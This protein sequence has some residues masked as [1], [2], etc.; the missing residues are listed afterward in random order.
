MFCSSLAIAQCAKTSRSL[1]AAAAESASEQRVATLKNAEG[2]PSKT[3]RA[4]G[5]ATLSDEALILEY[6]DT[7]NT[8]LFEE[9]VRRYHGPLYRF[10]CGYLGEKTLA[11]D[12]LQNTLLKVHLKC[13]LYL[14]GGPVW[15]WLYKIATRQAIDALRRD[16]RFASV[17]LA[18]SPEDGDAT[19]ADLLMCASP[20][21]LAAAQSAERKQIVRASVARLPE[22]FRQVVTLAYFE[23]MSYGEIADAL[24]IPLGTVK[25]RLHLAIGRL[26]ANARASR[27]YEA[28]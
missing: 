22:S 4:G 7:G 17:R 18:H 5:V 16:E 9:L 1:P 15:P 25:S 8:E 23:G 28:G 6:R 24:N 19:M 21:P 10:L 27:S 2:R 20:G 14:P 26:R 11:E 13:S 3:P 12:V